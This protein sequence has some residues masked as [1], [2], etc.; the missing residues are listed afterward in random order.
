[1]HNFFVRAFAALAVVTVSGFGASRL[2]PRLWWHRQIG[3]CVLQ[4]L[5]RVRMDITATP[6]N[7]F[8]RSIPTGTTIAATSGFGAGP[9]AKSVATF[10]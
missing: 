5:S 3:D 10:E 4:N 1:M 9:T 6:S 8:T 7:R 2:K